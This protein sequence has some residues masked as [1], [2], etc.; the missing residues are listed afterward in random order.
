MPALF[1]WRGLTQLVLYDGQSPWSGGKLSSYE[2]EWRY[3]PLS[4]THK[5]SERWA[6]YVRAS[7][8][9]GVGVH[10]PASSTFISYVFGG[11]R[12]PPLA[13]GCY[14]LQTA[15]ATARRYEAWRRLPPVPALQ[16]GSC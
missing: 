13:A 14:G 7:D 1:F 5:P 12:P 3:G 10:F 11:R 9:W 2:Q 8:Q 15:C 16:L 6:A 4:E